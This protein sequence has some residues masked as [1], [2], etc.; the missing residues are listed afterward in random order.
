M[1]KIKWTELLISVVSAELVG[2]LSALLSG[3]YSTRYSELIQ[4]P[5]APSGAV[6]PVVWTI[7]YAL[8]GISAYIIW[9]SAGDKSTAKKLYI[10]QLSVNF[11]WSIIF[12]RFGLLGFAA[13]W[14]VLL[15]VLVLAMVKAFGKTSVTAAYLNVPYLIWSAFASYLAIGTWLLNK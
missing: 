14:A 15:F 4:P 6:F 2:V 9:Q 8:M 7:L 13:I 10:A 11:L 1:K 3:D 5:F 12:F